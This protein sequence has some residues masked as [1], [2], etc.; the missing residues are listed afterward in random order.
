MFT[1]ITPKSSAAKAGL[2]IGL[3][4]ASKIVELHGGKIEVAS[5]GREKGS[6]FSVHL[7]RV[8]INAAIKNEN[9]TAAS[10]VNKR[11]LLVV[12]DLKDNADSLAALLKSVG[13][14][15][16]VAY[17]GASAIAT[18][19][20]F[21]PEI[22]LLDIGMPDMDGIEACKII[23]QSAWGRKIKLVAL[24]GWGQAEDVNQTREAGFDMHLVKPVNIDDLMKLVS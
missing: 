18:A 22:A 6:T 19:E 23:R 15:V 1:Q 7:P 13:H 21:Q 16:A 20:S 10:P 17:N 12:D 24:T 8:E 11:R 2:G 9:S 3:A 14:E 4:I 5:A